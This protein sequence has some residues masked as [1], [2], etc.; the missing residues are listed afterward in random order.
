MPLACAFDQG[1]LTIEG[2]LVVQELESARP[3]FAEAAAAP[4]ELV[5]DAGGV[6]RVDAAGL[7]MLTA[8]LQG[9]SPQTARLASP[10]PLVSRALE[11]A[12]LG[13]VVAP[14]MDQAPRPAPGR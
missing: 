7:Q 4:G 2:E 9:R 10:P 8:L 3:A 5:V 11:L 6:T 12:G 13:P 14:Y 1:R